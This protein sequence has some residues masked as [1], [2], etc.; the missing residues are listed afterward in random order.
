[1]LSGKHRF[2][3]AV[4]GYLER[5]AV[6]LDLAHELGVRSDRDDVLY[7]YAK[8]RG[9]SFVRRRDLS[10]GV[11]KQ[12]KGEPLILW[13]PTGRPDPGAEVLLAEGEPDA[14][15]ACSA[16]NGSPAVAAVPGT[17]IPVERVT[18]E[19]ASA[20]CVYLALDGD[21]PGREAANRFARALQQFTELRVVKLGEG[22][23]LASRLYGEPDPVGWLSQALKDAR[24]VPKLRLGDEP[25]GYGRRKPADKLRE[26][27][28]KGIDPERIDGAELLDE[29]ER[30]LRRF[31]VFG[32]RAASRAVALW[33]LH[34]HAFAAA[35]AT[36]YLGIVSPTKRCGK[37]RLEEVLKLLARDAWKIDGVPSE[38]TLFREIERVKPAVLLDEADALW[39]AGDVRT[40]PLRAVFNSGNRR[41]NTIPRCVGEGTKQEVKRFDVFSPKC[42]AGIKTKRWPDTVLDRSFLIQLRRRTRGEKVERLRLRK[43]EPEAELLYE[44]MA[45]WANANLPAL[46][47]AEPELPEELDD[48]AQDGA[49]PLLA[50]A[51][52]AGSE[53]PQR[54]RTALLELHE[55]RELE[56]DSWGI[57]LLADIHEAFGEDDRLSGDELRS[58]LKADPEK[59]WASWGKDDKGLTARSL[60]GLLRDFELK[61]KQLKID[62]ENKRGF[63]R[64]WFEDAWGRYLPDLGLSSA[65]SATSA[66]ES[67]IPPVSEVLREE[68]GSTSESGANPHE[69]REVAGVADQTPKTEGNGEREGDE[70]TLEDAILDPVEAERIRASVGGE[71]V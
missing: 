46:T 42:L 30:F 56:D 10:N 45:V 49:E 39:G 51:D 2:S 64:E 62:G 1:M 14:L 58:R 59:P 11:T 47:E 19:L 52:L 60:A 34:T 22:E 17:T 6:D 7:R 28:A 37:S 23:D 21:K 20:K 27:R 69:Q 70:H 16:L 3:P 15:A 25:Q 71:W 32:D 29:V 63:A 50:I 35:E 48:R 57:Q 36:P 4:C 5:H 67:Q 43:I 54:A 40:E 12:P 61:P 53:W 31:V 41:G 65:T 38:A 33:V 26:L 44:K 18:A 9:D 68:A 8:P 66:L 13:W 24:D 55:A